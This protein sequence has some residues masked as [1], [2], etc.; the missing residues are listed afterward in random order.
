M[1][2]PPATVVKKKP[3]PP[4]A[5]RTDRVLWLW[6]A[7]IFFFPIYVSPSGLPQPADVLIIILTPLVFRRWNGRMPVGAKRAVFAL[8]AFTLYVA[9]SNILWSVFTGTFDINLRYG[10]LLSPLFYIYNALVFILAI[11]MYRQ[12]G[13]AFIDMTVRAVLFTVIL[14][15]PITILF[16]HATRLRT[17]GMFN[18][19]NQL[20]YFAVLSA[21]MI[22][23]GQKRAKI[24]STWVMIGLLA[25]SYLALL[26]A[27]KAA[28]VSE[29][30]VIVISMV[31]KLRTVIMATLVAGVLFVTVDPVSDAVQR[32][33][34]RIETDESFGFVEERGYDRIVN[35]PEYL[36]LGA[37][38]GGYARFTDTTAIRQHELHSSAGTIIFCYG[39]AGALLFLLF[40]F[41]VL[42]V[43][44]VKQ[45]LMTLPV[46]A[47][48]LSHQ[49]LRVTLFWVFLAL[50][51]IIGRE[52][53]K[54][55][56][57]SRALAGSASP[58]PAA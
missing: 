49:G 31:S 13:Q 20:G 26:S 25:A 55:T 54:V 57:K 41:Q 2:K 3:V 53:K 21:S 7:F 39:I 18:A 22:L 45:I 14:Q 12:K 8:L 42:R 50:I 23:L 32:T 6:G 16:G 40:V 52:A 4:P 5:W 30:L 17:S 34:L 28:L 29:G 33:I 19:P 27:S 10:F 47:Y 1:T 36:V 11:V 35:N 44:D 58:A 15:V 51:I 38:E 43:A 56:A 48:G 24:S 37:G 9:V 46:A